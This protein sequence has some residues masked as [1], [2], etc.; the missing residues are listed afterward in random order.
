M[1]LDGVDVGR[2]EPGGGERLADDALL[3][4]AVGCRETAARAVLVDG[5][6]ADD[7]EDLVAVAAGVGKTFEQEQARA[8]APAGAVGRLGEGLAAPVGGQAALAAELQEG[9]RGGHDGD[10]AGQGQLAFAVAQGLDGEVQGDEGGGAG[11]VDG[12]G[13]ALEAEGVGDAAGGDAGG[14]AVAEVALDAGG[15][16]GE[17]GGVVVVHDAREHAG[18]AAAQVGRA[19]TG[20]FEGFPGQLQQES[21]LRVGGECLPG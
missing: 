8:L 20:A 10:A 11:G 13:G 18:G 3:G 19:Q 1:R 12:E 9:D 4:G 17:A 2:G 6:A 16:L 15:R 5:G 7:G 14:A 21:L